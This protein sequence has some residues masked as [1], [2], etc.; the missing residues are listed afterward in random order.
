MVKPAI[1]KILVKMEGVL[2]SS[3]DNETNWSVSAFKGILLDW[4]AVI[5]IKKGSDEKYQFSYEASQFMDKNDNS[6]I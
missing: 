2:K 6:V 1:H 5:F 3:A 4:P